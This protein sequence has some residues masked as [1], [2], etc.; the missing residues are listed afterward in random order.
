MKKSSLKPPETA[1]ER[2]FMLRFGNPLCIITKQD[3]RLSGGGLS[4]WKAGAAAPGR[5][6]MSSVFTLSGMMGIYI[7]LGLVILPGKQNCVSGHVY[8]VGAAFD[9][10]RFFRCQPRITVE[11]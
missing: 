9:F 1:G 2:I 3:R 8:S 5:F 4:G 6:F 11:L 7:I 10:R